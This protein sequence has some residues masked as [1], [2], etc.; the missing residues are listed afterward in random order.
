MCCS[1]DTQGYSTNLEYWHNEM[2]IQESS[3]F[4]PISLVQCYPNIPNGPWPY[5]TPH[6]DPITNTN[7]QG[8]QKKNVQSP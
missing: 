5:S 4:E 1:G 2:A 7:I 8:G 6:L 3:L